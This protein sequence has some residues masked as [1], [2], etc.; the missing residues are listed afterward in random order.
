MSKLTQLQAVIFD[1]AGTMVDFG[2]RAPVQAFVEA[3]EQ[4]GVT[5]TRAEARKP[6]GLPK[7]DHIAAMLDDPQIAA[8]WADVCGSPPS[9]HDID[10]LYDVFV[11][12]NASVAADHAA[13][14][15]GAKDVFDLLSSNDV[16]VGSTTGYTRAIMD[17][18][19][20]A[21]AQQGYTPASVVCADDVPEGRP[22]PMMM[23]RCFADLGVTEPHRIVKVDDTAPG[24][25]E[26]KAA[27]TWTVGVS[28]S[29]NAVGLTE[30]EIADMT[31]AERSRLSHSARQTLE[32]TGCDFVIDTVAQL[33][34]VLETIGE[35]L[36]EDARPSGH[37]T[38]AQSSSC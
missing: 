31:P 21:A 19:V 16:A 22:G 8:R 14:I 25:A 2:S 33:P 7:R 23:E 9:K 20:P 24:I 26:G 34:E 4:F 5:V 29:G 35:R 38:D 30:G 12:L 27:G 28:L 17:R 13:L 36:L 37:K 32:E 6:M 15:R 18:V 11:P 10:A 1:W 3:F